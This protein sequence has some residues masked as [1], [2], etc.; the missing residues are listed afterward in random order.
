MT[1]L[2]E[3]LADHRVLSH[4]E[5]MVVVSALQIMDRHAQGVRNMAHPD[6]GQAADVVSEATFTLSLI[7]QAL[8]DTGMIAPAG[9]TPGAA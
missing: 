1:P 7:L 4:D 3:A 6:A 2:D 8:V 9:Y 5:A